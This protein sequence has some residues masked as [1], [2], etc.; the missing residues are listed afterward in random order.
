MSDEEVPQVPRGLTL[1][2]AQNLRRDRRIDELAAR[3][4]EI[5]KRLD[6][7]AGDSSR[8]GNSNPNSG[9]SEE[10]QP[11]RN[12]RRPRNNYSSS[13]ESPRPRRRDRPK[14][15]DKNLRLDLP[16]FNGSM[17]EP[18]K[19]FEWIRRAE[20][21][22]D[23]KEYDER[24]RCKLAELKLTGYASLWYDNLKKKRHKEGRARISTWEQLKKHMKKRFV[25]SDY[26][27]DVYLKMQLFKQN[28]MT[29]E[30]Y[31]GEF[32]KL[33]M[34][35]GLEEIVE[36]KIA[37][38]ISGLNDNI[39]EKV[40]LQQYW[41]FEDV[42]KVALKVEKQIKGKKGT[43]TKPFVKGFTKPFEKNSLEK[44]G[45]SS[46]YK[47]TKS[48][49]EAPRKLVEDRKCFKCGSVGHI[50]TNCPSKRVMTA[51]EW[52][53]EQAKCE[54]GS[55]YE[56]K[57]E[58]E[59][60]E[61][62]EGHI[63]EID[64][65]THGQSLVLRRA[66]H[67]K[68]VPMENNQREKI[69]LT[70][71]KVEDR[72]CDMIID[73]GSCTNVVSTTLV[74][75]LKWPTTEHPS[76]YKLHWL[77]NSSDVKVTKQALI[78]FSIGKFHDKVLCDVC[79]MDACHILLGRP[80]QYD[81]FVKFDGRTNVYVVRKG[82]KE[83]PVALKPLISNKPSNVTSN[84]KSSYLISERELEKEIC[85][86]NVVYILVS[87]EIRIDQDK[88][89]K[90]PYEL[91]SVLEEFKDV[92]P[93][94]L[95]PGLPPIRG[96][97]HQIDLI[98]GAPLPNKAAYR[99]NPEETKEMQRQI[100]ELMTRGY[101]R[102]SMS[103]CAVPT[104]L[105]PKKDGSWR[106]CIDSRSVNNITIKYRFPIPRLDD[107]LDELH[108]SKLFSKIDLMSGYHQIRMREG[109]EW[110]TTFK[111]KLGLYEWLV[112][113]FGL[114]NAPSTFMRLMHEVLKPFLG[115]FVVVYLDDILIYSKNLHDHLN[116]L[117]SVFEVL[118]E[119][120][121]YAKLE[122]CYFLVP[123]VTFLGYVVSKDGVSVDHS[124][125][126][127]IKTWPIPTNLSEVRSF[128]GLASFYRR[129]VKNFSS[130][131]APMTECLKKDKGKF[132]WTK[133]AQSAFELVK[134]KLCEAPI[135]ALPDFSS[136][137]E[138]ETDASGVGIGAV[139]L[140]KKRPIA[141]FS[142]KLG[143]ARLNYST[144]DKEFY[145]IVRALDH[146][147]H[148]LRPNHFVLHSDHEAL[149]YIHGQQKLNPRHAT[150]VEFLQSFN[151]SSR[152]KEGKS[153]VVADA[154]SRRYTLIG[155][156]NSKLLGFELIK[157]YYK[158]D[159][160][161]A[162]LIEE[163]SKGA[164]G[165]YLLQDG[166]LFKGNRLCLPKC[167]IKELVVREAHG[168]G[169]AGHFGITKTLSMLQE[170]F[171]WPKMLTDVQLVISRCATCQK[172]KAT[173]HQGLYTPLPV[174]DSP[175]EDISMDFIVGLPRT[176]RGKDSIMV[177]VDRFSKM[178]HFVPCHKVDD[179]MK[180]AELYFKE[181]VRLHG[182]PKTIVSDRDTK[183]MSFFWKSLWKLVGTKLLFST[184]YHPQTDGQTEVT[185]RT[186]GALLRG[187]VSKTQKDWDI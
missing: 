89:A 143:G 110:K 12:P 5:L 54:Q 40:E 132:E 137:F 52:E 81:R 174:P 140:Q 128:H 122:K 41:S 73:T 64:P 145:A 93:K 63:D 9:S 61:E 100:E 149:K 115:K 92:F 139:L 124:K 75:K 105:V 184:S 125:V 31:I 53:Q 176:Q 167:S 119:K 179:A 117:T 48:K 126:E 138:V 173:F 68:T 159:D 43:Y 187:L 39:A 160:D 146:W 163:C 186:L 90:R 15:D 84:S 182:I 19:Y 97:E 107:L 62:K 168:G 116:H 33:C 142:E 121:L 44:S 72:L 6:T 25:P 38:F 135:L 118:R 147:S 14:D 108:G 30:N 166:F 76:P 34:L 2:Q 102:E 22:F 51:Q 109:D 154:L 175:W 79:P 99:S 67:S 114:T 36:H 18:E 153:N 183:F 87:N 156:L 185:N 123:S 10:E 94:E 45:S 155:I 161:F 85:S 113:P 11:R 136:P 169:I 69:F 35:C 49:F 26:I 7:L 141:Y 77:N 58:E 162:T 148:Y 152:Y 180:V 112:M 56:E 144:Y 181:I 164:V 4:D 1:E 78:S 46:N 91:E 57:N 134:K 28:S 130:I 13:D 55:D 165:S 71:C 131:V 157:E 86:N 21:L 65:E 8:K 47:E 101:V 3:M 150:W 111:T 24:K 133:E 17:N 171:Y 177:V 106:M 151:F 16:E 32:E 27:Q 88:Q 50:A 83:R 127:A 20:T 74:D 95:P 82:E 96:I 23:Y 103:P 129:F 98:P 70:R 120:K 66:L 170:H 59:N 42:C 172:A 80:W 158:G 60:F 37:R 104:L 29:V 178:A